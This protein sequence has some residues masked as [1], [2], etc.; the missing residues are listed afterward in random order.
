MVI[1]PS[2][3][4]HQVYPFYECEEERVSIPGN[5]GVIYRFLQSNFTV[6]EKMTDFKGFCFLCGLKL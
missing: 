5:F 4:K 6:K 1:F 3:M 2:R